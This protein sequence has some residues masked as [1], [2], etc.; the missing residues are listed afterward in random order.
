MRTLIAKAPFL[1]KPADQPGPWMP[2]GAWPMSWI[3]CPGATEPPIV[4]AYR[5]AF[6][7]TGAEKVRVHVS[8]D[9]RYVLYLDGNRIG[10]GPERGDLNHWFFETYDLDLA[11]GPHTIVAQVWSLGKDAPWAQ[12]SLR[13]GFLLAAEGTHRDDLSTGLSPWAA[14]KLGGYRFL[15]ASF[16]FGTGAKVDVDGS[17]FHWGFE[18]GEGDGW[19]P[20]VTMEPANS[21]ALPNNETPIVRLLHPA[22]LPAMLDAERHV[23][24]ARHVEAPASADTNPIRVEVRNHLAAEAEAWDRLAAGGGAFTV[25]P[26]TRRRILFD[27]ENYYCA[28][29]E[30]TLSGGRGSLVRVQWAEALYLDP[31]GPHKGNRNEI[32]GKYFLGIGDVFRPDGG[33]ARRFK[34]LWWEAGRYVELYVETADEP[35]V[36]D[37]LDLYEVRYPLE[38]ETRFE[39]S[40]ARLEKVVPIALR[41]LQ[42]CAQET[43]FDCPYYEQLMYEG[44]SR[45]EILATY[46][47]TRDDRLPRKALRMF[48]A[49]RFLT[50]F[51]HSRYPSRPKQVIPPFSIWYL[52]MIHD[53][54]RWRDDP[55][56][57]RRL[58][59]GAR[60][61]VDAYQGFRNADGLIEGPAG[62][63]YMDWVPA[64]PHG[65]PPDADFGV[66]GILNWHFVLGLGLMAELE[67]HMGEK[68]LAA[69]ME[70]LAA[71]AAKRATA[72]FWDAPRG[73]LADDLGH[74]SFSEH[75]QCLALLSGRL[76]A[77]KAKRA[78]AGLFG[79]EDLH[80]T[81]IYFT[82]YLFETCRLVGRMDKMLER[83]ELWFSLEKLGFKTP[84]EMPEPSRS[85]CHA[86][87]AHPIYHNFATI[88]GIRPSG[89]G[90]R[91]VEIAPQLGPLTSARGTL[92]HPKGTIKV[93][94]AVEGGKL[95]G[96]VTLPRGVTGTFRAG[97]RVVKL[98]EGSQEV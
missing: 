54:A 68:E 15:P 92:V 25:P 55:E 44:D 5:K 75:A 9:E 56:F 31:K 52:A 3:A 85:D 74:K 97:K 60:G 8:A 20:A 23:G 72:A 95:G 41:G 35:L 59:P 79:A 38:M 82:H 7:V 66:S 86:W 84:F 65:M 58:M 96:R 69:R 83:L 91:T 57:V 94:M 16:C 73:M 48:D 24:L 40:D 27:L 78:A 22:A 53:F 76:P 26:R 50:G 64:W 32:E 36:I 4:T 46:C 42:M 67:A 14:K 6:A 81:T 62:W 90:F 37:R 17:Q 18:R 33:P 63:N 1:L 12:L 43:Y 2:R 28:Y 77:A 71:E 34:T 21:A 11:A 10:R 80:R 19:A 88:L 51:T 13:P 93:D 70:R 30:A 98:H 29:P 39:A 61:V 45:L 89:W 49:S 47:T 87:A